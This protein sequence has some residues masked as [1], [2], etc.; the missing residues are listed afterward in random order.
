MDQLGSIARVVNAHEA[1]MALAPLLA[2]L[3]K[4]FNGDSNDAEHDAAFDLAEALRA[5][6]SLARGGK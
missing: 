6:L 2:K 1:F 3:E 5:A 4:T